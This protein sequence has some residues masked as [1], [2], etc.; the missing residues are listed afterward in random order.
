MVS[1]SRCLSSIAL[2]GRRERPYAKLTNFRLSS[3]DNRLN[4]SQKC[5]ARKE[6]GGRVG[7]GVGAENRQ[8]HGVREHV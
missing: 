8:Q 2:R 1:F 7:V 6:G 4:A 5:L 3:L